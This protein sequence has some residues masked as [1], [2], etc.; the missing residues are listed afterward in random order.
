MDPLLQLAFALHSSKGVYALL[1]GSGLSRSAEIPTGWEIVLDLVRRIASL[2]REACEPDPASWYAGKFGRAPEY[3]RVLDEVARLPAERNLLLRQYFEPNAEERER[4]AKV[5]TQA[6]RAIARLVAGGYIRLIVTT[7]FDALTERALDDIGISFTVISTPD[8]LLGALPIVHAGPTIVKV[9]GDY[10]DV[11]VRNTPA[12]LEMYDDATNHLLDR[13]FDEFGLVVCGWSAEWDLA[14]RAA[15]ER[16]PSRRFTTF[17]ASRGAPS[18]AAMRLI[19]QRAAQPISIRDADSFFDDLAEGVA[20]L[21]RVESRHPLSAKLAV[22]RLKKYLHE[23]SRRID[24]RDLVMTEVDSLWQRMTSAMFDLNR[25]CDDVELRARVER[26]ESLTEVLRL[27]VVEGCY[28]D[29]GTH[30]QVWI[31]VLERLGTPVRGGGVVAWIHLHA[32]PALQLLYAG[33]MAALAGNQIETFA[34]LLTKPTI[35]SDRA[36]PLLLKLYPQKVLERDLAQHLP[37]LEG[38][39]TPLSDRLFV[40]LRESLRPYLPDDLRYERT[41]DR[42][43]YLLAIVFADLNQK[44]AGREWWFPAGRFSW[45]QR[46]ELTQL[47]DSVG[48]ELSQEPATPLRAALF[49]RSAERAAEVRKAVEEL[50]REVESKRW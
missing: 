32:Y 21:G 43:E 36:R 26:Y 18:E 35:V 29:D 24:V 19:E 8:Q 11:R 6:H 47:M 1:L 17:W 49:D 41:F 44:V 23:P 31:E 7:N 25:Q 9:H 5:P 48:A 40:V 22:E 16:C 2:E 33:G 12:E 46:E 37:G 10:R 45:K 30:R 27:L 4:G 3:S 14:L 42:F 15:I 13:I 50:T 20:A 28:W 34:A 39:F 38:R